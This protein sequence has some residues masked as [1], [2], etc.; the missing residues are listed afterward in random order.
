MTPPTDNMLLMFIF[1]EL[2]LANDL[3]ALDMKLHPTERDAVLDEMRRDAQAKA[4]AR[5]KRF[6][7]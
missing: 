4:L 1:I 3:K 5:C 7:P 2:T 6:N